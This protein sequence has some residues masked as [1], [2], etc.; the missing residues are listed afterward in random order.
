MPAVAMMESG[1]QNPSVGQL[2]E[3]DCHSTGTMLAGRQWAPLQHPGKTT[4][5]N[6]G[7]PFQGQVRWTGACDGLSQAK[8]QAP[9]GASGLDVMGS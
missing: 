3:S 9:V 8:L 4:G 2:P 5:F 1:T 6:T 7:G